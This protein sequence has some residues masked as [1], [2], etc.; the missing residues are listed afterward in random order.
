MSMS[1]HAY[2]HYILLLS[3]AQARLSE[4]NF[5]WNLKSLKG[6]YVSVDV[7]KIGQVL[8]NLIS[9]ALKVS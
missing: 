8:R 6:A 2:T 3:H 5:S 1:A 9:N 7:N 4:I